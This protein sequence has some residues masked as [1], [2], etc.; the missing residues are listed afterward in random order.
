MAIQFSPSRVLTYFWMPKPSYL[1]RSQVHMLWSYV[2][3]LKRKRR[4][5]FDVFTARCDTCSTLHQQFPWECGFINTFILKIFQFYPFAGWVV[6]WPLK[7]QACSN[8]IRIKTHR[9]MVMWGPEEK[10]SCWSPNIF[11]ETWTNSKNFVRLWPC[12]SQ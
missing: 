4:K 12:C 10:H 1:L 8:F 9:G 7:I 3:L 11:L 2:S 5:W 6:C